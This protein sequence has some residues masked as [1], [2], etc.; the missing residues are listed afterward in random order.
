MTKKAAVVAIGGNS[1]I[2]DKAHQTVEDRYHAAKETCCHIV[3]MIEWGWDVVIGHGN[4]PRPAGRGGCDRQGLRLRAVG[5]VD[6]RRSVFYL[7]GGA[8]LPQLRQI[9]SSDGHV[10]QEGGKLHGVAAETATR[11]TLELD[12]VKG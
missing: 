9:Y 5:T 6:R 11:S 4:R 1:L 10:I 8:R 2:K 7:G 12:L 3:D